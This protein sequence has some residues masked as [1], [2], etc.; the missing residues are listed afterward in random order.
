M[1]PLKMLAVLAVLMMP[2]A[3]EATEK[4]RAMEAYVNVHGIGEHAAI[5]ENTIVE[6]IREMGK[7]PSSQ[8]PNAYIEL[9]GYL[10]ATMKSRVNSPDDFVPVFLE[11]IK[12]HARKHLIDDPFPNFGLMDEIKLRYMR[13]TGPDPSDIPCTRWK[14]KKT[15][16]V[17]LQ[18]IRGH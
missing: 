5:C 6:Y 14:E 7:M 13:M 18:T 8:I 15:W 16:N 4:E 1:N 11:V 10:E 17:V 9:G 2:F 3:A 12:A